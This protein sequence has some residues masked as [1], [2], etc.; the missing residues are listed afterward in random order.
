[1]SRQAV[2]VRIEELIANTIYETFRETTF[3]HTILDKRKC[4]IQKNNMRLID[5][6]YQLCSRMPIFAGLMCVE[7][8]GVGEW[9][10]HLKAVGDYEN[11]EPKHS[12]LKHLKIVKEAGEHVGVSEK[13]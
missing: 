10:I 12:L 9:G 2:D 8:E 7:A 5:L 4:K 13:F 3:C 1:M 11:L 6:C